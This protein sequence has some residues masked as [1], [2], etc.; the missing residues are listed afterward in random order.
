MGIKKT[1]SFSP[2]SYGVIYKKP[3]ESPFR[4]YEY[5]QT[6]GPGEPVY[7]ISK[8]T[9]QYFCSIKNSWFFQ[10]DD[11]DVITF[12]KV[13]STI[14][15]NKEKIK[16][17]IKTSE[18][19]SEDYQNLKY[20]IKIN[21][22]G[23]YYN[24]ENSN[25]LNIFHN[26]NG[27]VDSVILINDEYIN[28]KCVK[29]YYNGYIKIN[30]NNINKND[31]I[32]VI[33]YPLTNNSKFKEN[34]ISLYSVINDELNNN[35]IIENSDGLSNKKYIIK[36]NDD[37]ILNISSLNILPTYIL[38]NKDEI[39]NI[40]KIKSIN[41]YSCIESYKTFIV[42]RLINTNLINWNRNENSV[43]I[44]HGLNSSVNFIIN[45][46]DNKKMMSVIK[47]VDDNNIKIIFNN[48]NYDPTV[49]SITIFKIGD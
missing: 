36:L 38:I 35:Y 46:F 27:N 19:S 4:K 40:S 21:E 43:T 12:L 15:I 11:N 10:I 5:V 45:N 6:G 24:C 44:K 9:P 33:V 48:L 47:K 26:F 8:R 18:V 42:Q 13:E 7:V 34:E 3:G 30:F 39:T 49:F 22:N 28:D 20:E 14:F 16:L 32:E 31:K 23:S 2:Y 37:S 41:S 17:S 29:Y 25:S 1:K